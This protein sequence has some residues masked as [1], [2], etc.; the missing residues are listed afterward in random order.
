MTEELLR[1]K[2][3]N[4]NYFYIILCIALGCLLLAFFFMWREANSDAPQEQVIAYP[5]A[6]FKNYISAAGIVEAS[7]DNISL[8][9]PLNRIVDKILVKVGTRVKKGEALIRLDDSDLKAELTIKK[10]AVEN[11]I[12]Q[13][14]KLEAMPQPE[15]LLSAEANLNGAYTQFIQAKSQYDMVLGL[16]DPRAVS[17]EEINRRKYNFQDA[18]AKLAEAKAQAE[19]V[20]AGA[21]GPDIEIAKLDVLQAKANVEKIQAEIART[22]I[23]SPIDGTV[24]QIKIHEGEMPSADTSRNPII[25]IGNTEQMHLRVN[26]NQFNTPS[27][28]PDAQA[29]AY[30]QGDSEMAFPL[31]FVRV[32]PFLISKQNLR[33]EITEIVDTKV[34]Q[35]I[36]RFEDRNPP[37]FV[38]QQ[39]D[40]FIQGNTT[41]AAPERK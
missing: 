17:Q 7:S 4:R 16:Q 6:P 2:K 31:I 12:A 35:V 21:W 20:K 32:E 14:K 23:R 33:N 15:D 5:H 41:T 19:K 22:I 36:Y 29:I 18:E 10:I 27:F 34:L 11:A 24:L 28:H 37:L 9:T 38:G 13:L 26:I 1:G 30:R 25:I 39:M 40:V 3:M 8:G